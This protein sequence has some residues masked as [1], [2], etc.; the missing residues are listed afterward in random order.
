[1]DLINQLAD[2][3]DVLWC[4]LIRKHA[5]HV[6]CH[7]PLVML[8]ILHSQHI[9]YGYGLTTQIISFSQFDLIML[10]SLHRKFSMTIAYHWVLISSII[11]LCTHPIGLAEKPPLKDYDGSPDFGN[12]H[13]YFLL[14]YAISHAAMLIR[15]RL[16]ASTQLL[17]ALQLVT[18]SKFK[19]LVLMH[20]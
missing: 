12:V 19:Y 15:L 2:C 11:F 10:E 9:T 20:I 7:Y 1:M 6:L 17:F 8:L 3:I 4:W 18:G 13:Q 14:G 5:G 16:I